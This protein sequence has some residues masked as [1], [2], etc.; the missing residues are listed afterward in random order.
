MTHRERRVATLTATFRGLPVLYVICSRGRTL[1]TSDL[2]FIY[3]P[4]GFRCG[5][6]HPTPLGERY[7][8]FA[9]GVGPAMRAEYLLGPD[10][11][12]KADLLAA[13]DQEAAL[14]LELRREDG[15]LIETHDIGI[16]DTHY[17]LSIA[18]SA[19][20]DDVDRELSPEAEAE[21]AEML[22]EFEEEASW[23]QPAQEEET[24]FPRYQ[25]QVHL[26]DPA[27]VP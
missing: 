6:L 7:L 22:A 11:T 4:D 26:L 1:G 12:L 9:T 8:P 21:I 25:L 23:A 13:S 14:E 10:P 16:R 27:S 2:G 18:D 15:V 24:E 17:L 19:A 5:W 20:V 3:R